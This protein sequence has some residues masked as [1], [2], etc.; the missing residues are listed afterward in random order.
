MIIIIEN[1]IYWI[2]YRVYWGVKEW[3]TPKKPSPIRIG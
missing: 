1:F 2:G 3:S